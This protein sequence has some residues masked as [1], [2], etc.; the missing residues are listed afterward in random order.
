MQFT[1]LNDYFSPKQNEEVVNFITIPNVVLNLYDKTLKNPTTADE[2]LPGFLSSR[3]TFYSGDW[4]SVNQLITSQH[5]CKNKQAENIT[6][7]ADD[8]ERKFD[9]IL[10]S[11]TIYNP[12]SHKKLLDLM[13]TH[14][15]HDGQM[16]PFILNNVITGNRAHVS[17]PIHIELRV[18]VGE[19]I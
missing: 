7:D 15:K 18:I 5:K 1:G 11:E 6:E 16:Y 10:T 3:A 13:T 19:K 2:H 4:D 9:F 8:E 12:S 14:L 17:C